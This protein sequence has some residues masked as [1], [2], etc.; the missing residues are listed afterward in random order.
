MHGG[1]PLVTD[2]TF[3]NSLWMHDILDLADLS[4]LRVLRAYSSDLSVYL[5]DMLSGRPSSPL[6]ELLL[7]PSGQSLILCLHALATRH[8]SLRVLTLVDARSDTVVDDLQAFIARWDDLPSLQ[9]LRLHAPESM[10]RT[11]L[12]RLAES[13]SHPWRLAHL[14]ELDFGPQQTLSEAT[15]AKIKILLPQIKT[16]TRY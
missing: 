14:R 9:I 12:V 6:E 8:S 13:L 5:S 11:H 10:R 1:F 2:L 7:D 16:I 4:R 3:R 15:R